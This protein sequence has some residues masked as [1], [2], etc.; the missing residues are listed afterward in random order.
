MPDASTEGW[1]Y[2][3]SG[4]TTG[5]TNGLNQTILYG[6]DDAGR[7]TGVDY[8]TGTDSAFSYDSAGRRTQMTD[9]SGTTSWAFDAAGQT[10]QFAS[11]QGS[12][13]WAYNNAGQ[14]TSMT[15]V[16]LGATTYSYDTAGRLSSLT[17][18]FS[19]LTSLAYDTLG[20]V[21]TK[22][23]GSGVYETY[24]YD[25]RG[26]ATAI[27]L[28]NSA[29]ATLRS[30]SYGFNDASQVVS[31]TV[32]G[33]QTTYGYDAIGQLL[34]ETRSGYAGSYTFDAN[35]NRATR[36]VNGV[37]ETYSVDSGDKLTAVTWSGSS[38][39]F[40]YDACG[41][42][43][44][45]TTGSGTTNLSY[46][47]ESRVTG[48]TYPSAATNSFGYSAFDARV[49]KTDSAGTST[50]RRAGA[51]VLSA[52]LN[53]GTNDFTP[54]VS[55][56][57]GSTST[58]SHSGLKNADSQTS[59]S[60][61]ISGSKTFDAYGN[62]VGSTG[63]WQG[64]FGYGGGFGYQSDTD[65]S[66]KLLGHRYYDSS[67]GRFLTRD[68]IK[69]GRNWYGYCANRPIGL[70]D[71]TGLWIET[72]FDIV[73]LG[74]GIA[75]FVQDPSVENG[76][77]VAVDVIFLI[78]PLPNVGAIRHLDDVGSGVNSV[79]NIIGHGDELGDF[80]DSVPIDRIRHMPKKRGQAPIG[81]DGHPL[82]IHHDGQDP[83]GQ[84]IPMTRTDHRGPGA[85]TDN[86]P[87]TGQEPTKGDRSSFGKKRRTL[88]AAFW[89]AL[90]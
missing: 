42:T 57:A 37:V 40:G 70:A 27:T 58:F 9:G 84:L 85:Y 43:T 5:Y 18:R 2:S 6:Y 67:T 8:P 46:D 26:R 56:R 45:I 55:S 21:A 28:K 77:G 7:M 31:H 49:S 86:H 71:P 16:G 25:E 73:M 38:K 24:S 83:G 79:N 36:T 50:Y 48:L 3:A 34:S 87:N 90:F 61:A 81:D 20:R 4:Q 47:Y 10:T 76:I 15:A 13:Q 64:P 53:D 30:Q 22:T 52:V 41:R 62:L 59:V 88:W 63:T 23:F 75:D 1:A 14:P 65:S 60:Q 11:P 51:G 12:T 78:A 82:E 68:P 44:S 54:G 17:N 69:D 66:L 72:G 32:D 74:V 80:V 39:S 19:E 89:D 29:N 35:G 33:T